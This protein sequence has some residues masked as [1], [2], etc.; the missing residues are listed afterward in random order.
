MLTKFTNLYI[1]NYIFF[2]E[3]L[4]CGL[5]SIWLVEEDGSGTFLALFSWNL[6]YF[7]EQNFARFVTIR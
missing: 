7:I 4:I 5:N 3:M 2:V 1:M 6:M